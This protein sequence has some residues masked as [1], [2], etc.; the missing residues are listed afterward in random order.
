MMVEVEVESENLDHLEEVLALYKAHRQTLGFMPKGGF[1]EKALNGTLLVAI[2]EEG[3]TV[4]YLLYDLPKREIAIRHLCVD[5]TMTSRGVARSLVDELKN[6]HP[7]RLGIRVICRNDFPAHGMWP[8]LDFVA[9][10]EAPGRSRERLPLT[11]WWLDFGHPTLFSIQPDEEQRIQIALDMDVF[12]DLFEEREHSEES[13]GLLSDW[14]VEISQLVITKTLTKEIGNNLDPE[15]RKRNRARSKLF[16]MVTEISDWRSVQGQLADRFPPASASRHDRLD[17]EH[18]ARSAAAQVGYFASRDDRLVNRYEKLAAERFGLRVR[19]PGDL[20][21]ELWEQISEP[22]S[23]IHLEN[24]RISIEQALPEQ[25]GEIFNSFLNSPKGERKTDIDKKLRFYRRHPEDWK[26]WSV[27]AA[28]SKL[29]AIFAHSIAGSRLEVP[30]F[31]VTGRT[32]PTLGRHIAQYLRSYA[33]NSNYSVVKITDSMISIQI[34][35]GLIAEGFV[36]ADNAWWLV[37]V[38]KQATKMNL[39]DALDEFTE[40]PKQLEIDVAIS[41]LRS[42]GLSARSVADL[43]HRFWPMKIRSS[44]LPTYLIPIK[45]YWAEQLFDTQL[46]LQTLFSRNDEL[47]ISREHIYYSG[48]AKGS[49]ETPARILW[50]VSRD[51]TRAGTGAIRAASQL[52]EL[53][54][55]RPLDLYG[56]FSHLGVYSRENVLRIGTK[57]KSIMALRF[58]DTEL[59]KNPISYSELKTCAK[60]FGCNLFVQA[61]NPLPDDM[62][63]VVYEKGT[64][65]SD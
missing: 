40:L 63:D 16:P 60:D 38:N 1:V 11:W 43:E 19:K 30:L 37:A 59:F 25:N 51:G 39:A 5:R 7:E 53:K 54:V 58:I 36:Q 46:S 20:L 45:P 4:G 21:I 44:A 18:I 17:L 12:I 15:I 49:L 52:V 61:I 62:F 31:R 24:T 35:K 64:Y 14:M 3:R 10:K 65:G 13:R 33:I 55:G 56:R 34:P 23:P 2:D 42:P 26:V 29:I 50:Y 9:I 47:G 27:R 28:N 22:Y 48:A 8:A 57:G 32:G 6:R 41:A